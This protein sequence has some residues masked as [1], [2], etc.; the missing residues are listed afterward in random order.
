MTCAAQLLRSKAKPKRAAPPIALKEATDLL[1]SMRQQQSATKVDSLAEEASR[2]KQEETDQT[3][4]IQ[5]AFGMG[6]QTGAAQRKKLADDREKLANDLGAL[7]KNLQDTARELATHNQ[8]AA[9]TKLREALGDMQQSDLRARV[10]RG[11][12]WMRRGIDPNANGMEPEIAA[13]MQR[14][15]KGVH[16]AQTAMGNAPQQGNDSQ[17]GIQTALNR[18]ERLRNQLGGL[19]R[20][21]QGRQQGQGQGQGQ[22]GG[23]GQGQQGGQGQNGGQQYGRGQQGGWSPNG[24]P[25]AR[26]GGGDY[27]GPYGNTNGGGAYGT[28]YG[29]LDTGNNTPRG[30]SPIQPDNSPVPSQRAYDDTLR[31][32][33]QLRQAVRDDPE[34]SKQVLDLIQEMARLD[35]ARFPGNP[36]LVEQLHSQVLADVDKL[37]LQLRRQLDDKDAGQVRS[38]DT[39]NVP[40]GYEEPVAEYYRRLSKN[41]ISRR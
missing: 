36:A 38:G 4:R 17:Q 31:E 16:D 34:T 30:G 41:N 37:E 27:N 40:Q 9:S 5:Q 22:Q 39:K 6:S 35:P 14:L 33:N 28:A 15:E 21:G 2:L 26:M 32:L 24:G 1:G 7:E 8:G 20:D 12:D 23:Q 18:V 29:N 13:G 25:G 10:Q 3:G 11:A 19:S